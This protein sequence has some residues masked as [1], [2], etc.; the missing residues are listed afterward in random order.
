MTLA[1]PT[2]PENAGDWLASRYGYLRWIVR[3]QNRVPDDDAEDVVQT[4][5]LRIWQKWDTWQ[6]RG[7][8]RDSW[9]ARIA[10]NAAKDWW[11]YQHASTRDARITF[12]LEIPDTIAQ[13]YGHRDG[14]NRGQATDTDF[15]LDP[16]MSL[17]DLI[18][19]RARLNYVWALLTRLERELAVERASGYTIQEQAQMR[20]TTMQAIKAK[21]H[22]LRKRVRA[23]AWETA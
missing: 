5:C 22:R 19:V 17:E 18:L 15:F 16:A 20:G 3:Q 9:A 2:E 4:A 6:D 23:V 13:Q 21:E 12:P 8:G 7:H 14:H 10:E 1:Q 11:R